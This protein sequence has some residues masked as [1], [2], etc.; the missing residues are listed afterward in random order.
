MK[1]K[2]LIEFLEMYEPETELIAGSIN[3]EGL[4]NKS[5]LKVRE[6]YPSPREIESIGEEMVLH[7]GCE[8]LEQK[9]IMFD[10]AEK[11]MLLRMLG[12]DIKETEAAL[13]LQALNL[14]DAKQ[15][16]VNISDVSLLKIQ[17]LDFLEEYKEENE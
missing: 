9:P 13:I 15:N 16:K 3:S 7:F 12:I 2:E 17:H 6:H 5:Y 10:L 14:Y 4:I 8:C 11:T 1:V